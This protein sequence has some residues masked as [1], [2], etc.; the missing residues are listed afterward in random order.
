MAEDR[1]SGPQSRAGI[2]VVVAVGD[3]RLAARVEAALREMPE[4]D[5]LSPDDFGDDPSEI[6]VTDRVPAGGHDRNEAA[7]I[8]LLDPAETAAALRAGAAGVIPRSASSAELRVAVAAVRHGLLVAPAGSFLAVEPEEEFAALGGI[9]DGQRVLTG[10]EREV[11]SLMAEGASNKQIA[12]R[13]GVSVHTA[14]FHVASILDKLDATGRTDAVA[15]A[16]RLG[17]LL[18]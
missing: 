18:L 11:L 15:H 8:C 2:T 16:V 1:A 9:D 14:K 5:V 17:L 7:V 12:R 13:L 10:R 4:L 6:L 3:Q